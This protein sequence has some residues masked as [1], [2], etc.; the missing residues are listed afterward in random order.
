MSLGQEPLV[1]V[2]TPVYDKE[3]FLVRV[4]SPF[5]HECSEPTAAGYC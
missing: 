3:D 5:W 1:T 4:S 2:L